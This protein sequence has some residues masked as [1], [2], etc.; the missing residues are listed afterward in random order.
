[1][2]FTKKGMV[3]VLLVAIHYSGRVSD[4]AEAKVFSKHM[5]AGV[6][7]SLWLHV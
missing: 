4:R 5:C 2:E 6:N 7:H 3:A 1:M